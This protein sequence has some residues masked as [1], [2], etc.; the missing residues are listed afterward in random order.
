MSPDIMGKVRTDHTGL[1]TLC[2]SART[3]HTGPDIMGNIR[4]DHIGVLTLC[5]NVRTDHTGPDIKDGP[6]SDMTL[7]VV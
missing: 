5:V 7:W 6:H 3:D 1:L 2:V 4:M